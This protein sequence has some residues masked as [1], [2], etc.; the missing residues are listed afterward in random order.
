M[1]NV[2]THELFRADAHINGNGVLREQLVR[3]HVF[4]GANACD[5]G[6]CMKFGVGDL[7]RDHVDFVGI[8][9]GDDDVGIPGASA[10]QNF[11]ISGVANHRSNIE[12]VL[13]FA[14]DVRAQVDNR[15]FV[16]LLARQVVRRR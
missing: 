11:G 1:L 9:Q 3:I 7:A 5:L 4:G 16:G 8:G 14:Q 15:D 13:Q 2:R 10:L 12:A 6:R